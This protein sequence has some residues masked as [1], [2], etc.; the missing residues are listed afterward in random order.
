MSH[1]KMEG[2]VEAAKNT[3]MSRTN[4]M[5][6]ALILLATLDQFTAVFGGQVPSWVMG[7]IGVVVM[8]LRQ[9]TTK[10]V[11]ITAGGGTTG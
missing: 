9:F 8:V 5:G 7:V 2:A 1:I 11:S 3:L 6:I 10:P 4:W